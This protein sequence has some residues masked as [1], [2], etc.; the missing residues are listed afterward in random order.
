MVMKIRSERAINQGLFDPFHELQSM[1]S[2]YS[3][4]SLMHSP[5]FPILQD[6]YTY[7]HSSHICE[8]TNSDRRD[9]HSENRDL[10][11][12]KAQQLAHKMTQGKTIVAV[13]LGESAIN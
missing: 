3:K 12:V 6:T 5:P 11:L 1:L 7:T 4:Y 9:G 2:C 10:V 13:L 8:G